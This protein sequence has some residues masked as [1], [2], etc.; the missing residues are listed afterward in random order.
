RTTDVDSNTRDESFTIS[1][2]NLVEDNNAPTDLSNGIELNTD[3][4]NDAY[5][6]AAD[7]G[8]LLG[9]LTK[10]T[11][12]TQFAVTDDT[13]DHTLI[14]YGGSTG[15]EFKVQYFNTTVGGVQSRLVVVVNN[16]ATY[17]SAI[18]Y[19]T[20]QDGEVHSLATS[21]DSTNGEWSVYIDGKLID[22]GTGLAIG[23]SIEAGGTL[24][25]GQEQDG[26]GTGFQTR[27]TLKATL[28]DVRIW[29]EVRSEAEIALNHQHKFDSG[30]LP[31]GLIANWQMDGFDGS[32]EVVDVVS[33]NNLSIAN[34]GAGGGF[35]TSTPIEDLHVSENAV[36]G[37]SVGFVV[38]SDPDSRQDVVDDGLFNHAGATAYVNVSTGQTIG[39]AGGSWTVVSG[40]VDLEGAWAESPLGGTALGLDGTVPGAIE[41]TISTEAGRQYQVVFALTGNFQGSGTNYSLRVSADGEGADF[42][43]SEPANWSTTNLLWEH[44]SLTFTATDATTDLQIASLSESGGLGAVIGDVQVIEIPQAVST[45]LNNDPTLSYDAATKKFYRFVNS[46][47]DF[48]TAL[49]AA[50]GSSLNGVSGEMVTIGS[51]YENELIRQHVLIGGTPIW[52][53]INDVSNDGTWREYDGA[54]P[55]GDVIQTSGTAAQGKYLPAGSSS[56]LGSSN[57]TENH[58]R[59][60]STGEWADLNESNSFNYVVQWDASEVLSSFTFNL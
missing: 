26:N 39:G 41:Q 48:S 51:A 56:D 30:S 13:V 12:E 58:A 49:N 33:G 50:T 18:D 55:D 52:L 53:G 4:G 45:I 35:I 37:G 19:R 36:D 9:G 29:N 17:S 42:T 25:F 8:A 57:P 22:S 31:S 6:A 43:V 46:P 47:S 16:E 21:W 5:L 7:G 60:V 1:L 32:N 2:N 3:G 24:V 44:R 10:L 23:E 27:E 54:N 15:N 38:P 59:M 11:F 28:Y 34:V 40:D 14:S 20:L